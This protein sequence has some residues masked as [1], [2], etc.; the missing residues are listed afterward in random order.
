MNYT[1]KIVWITGASSGIGEA[2]TY[3]FSKEKAKIIISARRE[4]ELERVK[5]N[6]AEELLKPQ[7]NIL[8]IF[9]N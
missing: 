9:H 2:L 1:G 8:K 5:N 6:C 3:L 4:S 7:N